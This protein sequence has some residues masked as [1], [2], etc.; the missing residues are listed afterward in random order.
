MRNKDVGNWYRNVFLYGAYQLAFE[1]VRRS[2]EAM[3]GDSQW[4]APYFI[5]W[6]GFSIKYFVP[7][8]VWHLMLWN[9]RDD[10]TMKGGKFYGGYHGFWQMAGFVY[11]I[12]GLICFF[13]PVCCPP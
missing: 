1:V 4:W 13:F 2:D 6:W 7:F 5:A 3:Q 9:F 12:I 11:P 8:A 10:L